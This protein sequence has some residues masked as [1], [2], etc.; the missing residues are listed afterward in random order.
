MTT[1]KYKIPLIPPSNNK[2]IGNGGKGKNFEYQNEKK[3]WVGYVNLFCNP[4][5]PFPIARAKVTLHYHFKDKRRR[6]PDNY[7]GKFL[8]DGLVRAGILQDDSFAV[9]N[10]ELKADVDINKQGYTVIEVQQL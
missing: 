9:I 1:Y 7:S 6:D 4:K 3:D 5:P 8:L 2:Y 10:L